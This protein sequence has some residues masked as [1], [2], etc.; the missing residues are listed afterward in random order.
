MVTFIKEKEQFYM[1]TEIHMKENGSILKNKIM[2]YW[3]FKIW[4]DM[5][6]N[7]IMIYLMEKEN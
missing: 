4:I 1:I 5:K 2:E 7:S 3:N 6:E